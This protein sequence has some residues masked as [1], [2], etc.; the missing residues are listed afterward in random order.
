MSEQLETTI[1]EGFISVAAV[2]E[3]G[4][5]DV[6]AVFLG[7]GRINGRIRWLLH[8]CEERNVPVTY[9]SAAEIDAKADGRSHGGVLAV[10]GS[11]R[12]VPLA[13][14][15]VGDAPFVVMLDG[16]EDPF[17]F[18]QAVRAFYAAGAAGLVVRPRNWLSAAG[19]VARASAG[20][21]EQMAIA[22]ADTAELAAD[23]YGE[24]GLATA[25]L[26]AETAV[27]IYDADLT[28]PLFLLV[29]GEKRGITRSFLRR[30]DMVLTIPY[31]RPFAHS[32]GTTAAA[33]VLAFEMHRQRSS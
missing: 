12:F 14:L 22:V 20:A 6:H 28:Q 19:V 21:S 33:A 5:R 7:E 24:Q 13:A 1:I 29:G 23:F 27:S 8:R 4:S 17:N 9:L 32:L 18:G 2:F 15:L 3:A 25:C 11:R 10:V 16:V 31:G 30:A 26:A